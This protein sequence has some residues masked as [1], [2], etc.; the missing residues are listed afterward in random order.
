MI[1]HQVLLAF[2]L[3]SPYAAVGY[4][5][6]SC[7]HIL[8]VESVYVKKILQNFTDTSHKAS[9]PLKINNWS[10]SFL[11]EYVGLNSK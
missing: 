3:P 1:A 9:G 2:N 11:R 8:Q 10:C 5:R 4:G 6:L 7:V